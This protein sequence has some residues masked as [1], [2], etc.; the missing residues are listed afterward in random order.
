M[1]ESRRLWIEAGFASKKGRLTTEVAESAMP[2]EG[3]SV[4]AFQLSAS[5][6]QIEI[7]ISHALVA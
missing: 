6:S 4:S 1:I 3:L 7:S 5:N 2:L